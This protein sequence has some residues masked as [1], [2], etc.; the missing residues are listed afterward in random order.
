MGDGLGRE[1]F[2]DAENYCRGILFFE[3]KEKSLRSFEEKASYQTFHGARVSRHVR[4][5]VRVVTLME[6]DTKLWGII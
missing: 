3:N 5:L 6:P 1:I 4:L 2:V